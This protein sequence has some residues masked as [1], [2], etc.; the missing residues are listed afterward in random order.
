MFQVRSKGVLLL[1]AVIHKL[2]LCF[3]LAVNWC[4]KLQGEITSIGS[5][6]ALS[7]SVLVINLVNAA[8]YT[9]SAGCHDNHKAMQLCSS[10]LIHA[11]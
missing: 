2:S 3:P 7:M 11:V 5:E 10:V 4:F 9:S 6:V 8:W 1:L